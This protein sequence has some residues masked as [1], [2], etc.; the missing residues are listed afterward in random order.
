[1]WPRR[2]G[3]ESRISRW[4]ARLPHRTKSA[5]AELSAN[6]RALASM[7][8]RAGFSAIVGARAASSAGTAVMS[9]SPSRLIVT[10]PSLS[11]E[12]SY[13]TPRAYA[14][15]PG[16]QQGHCRVDHRLLRPG[17]VLDIRAVVTPPIGSAAADPDRQDEPVERA[18]RSVID[19]RRRRSPTANPWRLMGAVYP[20]SGVNEYHRPRP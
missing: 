14:V 12:K 3:G 1:M 2:K 19:A 18:A 20:D 15:D 17:G 9:S 11:A 4:R 16:A 6:S 8:T 7:M 5:M 10:V 13:L